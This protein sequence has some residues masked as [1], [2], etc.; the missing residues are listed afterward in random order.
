M[1]YHRHSLFRTEMDLRRMEKA[2]QRI[3][4][5]VAVIFF[6]YNHV[7]FQQKTKKASVRRPVNLLKENIGQLKGKG[8]QCLFIYKHSFSWLILYCS[9]N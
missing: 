9:V 6:F 2:N 4:L 1:L 8:T 3:Q 5:Y 7:L